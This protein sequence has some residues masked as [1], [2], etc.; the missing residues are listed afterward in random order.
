MYQGHLKKGMSLVNTRTNKP[1]KITRLVKMHASD[2]VDVP[3]VFAGDIFAT[4]GVDCASG[5]TFASAKNANL[6]MERMFVPEGV[7]SMSIKPHSEKHVQN[8]IKALTRF[9]NEVLFYFN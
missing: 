5:D 8:F 6:S 4:F 9:S 7:V 2:M 3:E 1:V